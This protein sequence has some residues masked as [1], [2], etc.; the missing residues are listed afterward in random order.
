[1]TLTLVF[2]TGAIT[3]I[4]SLD[5]EIAREY[6]LTVQ[7]SDGG[8]PTLSNTAI[9][10]INVTDAND[11]PPHFGQSSYTAQVREDASLSHNIVQVQADDMDSA[12]NSM[13]SYAIVSGDVLDQ[14]TI[15][16]DDGYISVASEL[17]REQVCIQQNFYQ[18]F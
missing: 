2:L 8:T 4:N 13:V 18:R 16:R 7:A 9:I 10:K 15:N 12:P 1:M 3:I 6:F 17:N 5:Y 11:N 14:F